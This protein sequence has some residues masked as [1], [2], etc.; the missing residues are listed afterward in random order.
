[1]SFNEEEL[2]L[3]KIPGYAAWPAII[4]PESRLP[5]NVL[6]QKPK[7]KHAVYPVFFLGDN[8]FF[9]NS[10]KN[11]TKIDIEYIEKFLENPKKCK[12]NLRK[13]FEIA[14]TNPKSE[15]VIP[16]QPEPE[17]EPESVV[18][19]QG[20]ETDANGEYEDA[21]AD[22]D[23]DAVADADADADADVDIDDAAFDDEDDDD[24]EVVVVPRRKSI[25]R[26]KSAPAASQKKKSTKLKAKAKSTLSKN[27]SNGKKKTKKIVKSKS[28]DDIEGDEIDGEDDYLESEEEEEEEEESSDSDWGLDDENEN[29]TDIV[30]KFIPPSKQLFE[31][32]NKHTKIFFNTRTL[33]QEKLLIPKNNFTSAEYINYLKN[34]KK[35]TDFDRIIQL[36]DELSK[37]K[38]AEI[39]AI[40]NTKLNK[41]LI[42]LL[43]KPEIVTINDEDFTKLRNKIEKLVLKWFEFKVS[44][45]EHWAFDGVKSEKNIEE[46]NGLSDSK[47]IQAQDVKIENGN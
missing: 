12:G 19:N 40:K 45:D 35:N 18:E 44:T 25:K 11:L 41:V 27:K 29:N 30:T 32:I 21:E 42:H 5:A 26:K 39:S 34:F 7:V 2:V 36:I 37:M 1:M 23:A 14:K 33:L 17:P 38:T 43:Q 46:K 15:D 22:V 20:F 24:G 16:K 3:S 28:H 8:T 31:N 9:W 4:C 13:A 47:K 10:A 6:S